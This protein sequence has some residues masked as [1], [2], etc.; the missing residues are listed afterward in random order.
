MRRPGLISPDGFAITVQIIIPLSSTSIDMSLRIY[1]LRGYDLETDTADLPYRVTR[2]INPG[3][4]GRDREVGDDEEIEERKREEG[5]KR[6]IPKECS[7][8]RKISTD[9]THAYVRA[10]TRRRF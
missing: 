6:E 9:R 1:I 7:W 8:S 5:K 2:G 10:H 4:A 3:K